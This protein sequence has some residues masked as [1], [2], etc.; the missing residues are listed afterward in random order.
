[1][2][3]HI[4]QIRRFERQNYQGSV[5]Y[6]QGSGRER[7]GSVPLLVHRTGTALMESAHPLLGGEGYIRG[8]QTTSAATSL[9]PLPEGEGEL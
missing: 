2:P 3:R 4:R 5:E 9:N 6:V 7:R 1:M 8:L